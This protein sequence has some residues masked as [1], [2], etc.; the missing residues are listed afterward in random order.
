MADD[1]NTPPADPAGTEP[2]P[3]AD[4]ATQPPVDPAGASGD[5]ETITLSKKDYKNLVAQRDKANNDRSATDAYVMQL[6]KKEEIS[7]WHK[8][9]ASEYP[10]V[11]IDDLMAAESEEDLP[12]IAKR[13]Q[14]RIEDAVQAK[15]KS[16]QRA[17]APSISPEERAEK[18]KKLSGNNRPD[19][20]FE[21][22]VDLRMT[23]TK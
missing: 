9:H 2:A 3:S 5:D 10:D 18:L 19:D 23:P 12:K 8:E 21:Q 20:A 17:S 4:P 13:T 7:D 11:T 14:R 16:V 6:A 1:Q 15:L 22:M